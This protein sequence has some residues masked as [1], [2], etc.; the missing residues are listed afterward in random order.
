[1]PVAVPDT[2]VTTTV[3]LDYE[4]DQGVPKTSGQKG[5]K[6]AC[7][8][9][10]KRTRDLT[11]V[12]EVRSDPN[13]QDPIPGQVNVKGAFNFA[14]NMTTAVFFLQHLTNQFNASTGSGPYVRT[15]KMVGGKLHT[16]MAEKQYG[17]LGRYELFK[18][19]ALMGISGDFADS[20]LLKWSADII[21]MDSVALS[22]SAYDASVDDW[23]VGSKLH[24]GMLDASL[25][26]GSAG[27]YIDGVASDKVLKSS[28]NVKRDISTKDRPASM[29]GRLY[30]LPGKRISGGGNIDISFRSTSALALLQDGLPHELKLIYTVSTSPS[31]YL[32]LRWSRVFFSFTSPTKESDDMLNLSTDWKI[33]NDVTNSSFDWVL[34]NDKADSEYA[35]AWVG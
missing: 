29:S 5:R 8:E 20:G 21:G 30:S 31:Y 17:N 35:Q 6:F 3:V 23:E 25:V 34:A 27:V 33:A 13:P 14:P 9:T 7:T 12:D 15:G 24:H 1:M 28:Y 32:Q 18:G 10:L 4:E 19:L 22:S 11:D 16:F 2:G 26:G